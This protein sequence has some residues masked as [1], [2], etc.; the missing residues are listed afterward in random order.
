[1]LAYL[2]DIVTML[3]D[4]NLSMQGKNFNI[5]DQ[6]KKIASFKKKKLMFTKLK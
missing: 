2:V 4:L 3:N 5:F 6:S 1:M